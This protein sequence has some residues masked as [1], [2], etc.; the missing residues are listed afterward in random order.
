MCG[1]LWIYDLHVGRKVFIQES[2]L[3]N[4]HALD[5]SPPVSVRR[6]FR[7][8]LPLC[9]DRSF[10]LNGILDS[11]VLLEGERG[12]IIVEV[13]KL[14]PQLRAVVLVASEDV[15]WDE[16]GE[17]VSFQ[18]SLLFT[19][20]PQLQGQPR[21]LHTFIWEVGEQEL[22]KRYKREKLRWHK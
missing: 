11:P 19:P 7:E 4:Q 5:E 2:S 9:V 18:F 16:E 17:D 10:L 22:A 21:F 3:Y 14:A 15:L 12:R 13:K 6:P 20:E 1:T 8:V